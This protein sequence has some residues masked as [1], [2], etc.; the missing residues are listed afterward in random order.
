MEKCSASSSPCTSWLSELVTN[1][2]KGKN[3]SLAPVHNVLCVYVH[4]CKCVCA[5]EGQMKTLVSCSWLWFSKH[6][7]EDR[8]VQCELHPA[9]ELLGIVSCFGK[10]YPNWLEIMKANF[11][12]PECARIKSPCLKDSSWLFLLAWRMWKAR[13]SHHSLCSTFLQPFIL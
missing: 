4:T 5:Q 7:T 2:K 11:K 12:F 1:F 10:S 8:H 3:V 6:C 13:F 9:S